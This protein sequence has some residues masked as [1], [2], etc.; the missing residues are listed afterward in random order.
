MRAGLRFKVMV[1]PL[2][3]MS[4]STV[5]LVGVSLW[6]E[7]YLWTKKVEEQS[8]S[9]AMLAK[10][11][12]AAIEKQALTI[13]AIAAE[14]P[15]VEESYTLATSGQ[16]G[17][18]R[19]LL[20]K[21]TDPIHQ[22]VTETLGIKK[23]KIHFHLPPAKSFLRIWEEA[24]KKDGGEDISGFR[25]S[26]VKVNQEKKP[27][28]A[29]EVGRGGFEV[30]GIVP[31]TKPAGEHLGSV[32]TL[33]ELNRVFETAHILDT[34]DMA[35]YMGVKEL[36]IAKDLK[37]KRLP[38]TAG[39]VRIF[40]SNKENTD[41]YVDADLL[42]RCAS[43]DRAA[44]EKDGRLLTA[45]PLRDFSGDLKGVLVF[46]RDAS[47]E[48]AF[49]KTLEWALI[50]GGAFL[51]SAV[52]LFLYLSSSSIITSL[53]SAINRLEES[54]RNVSHSSNEIS[55]SSQTVASGASE[56]AAALEET[57]ASMEETTSMIKATAANS[58]EADNLMQQTATITERAKKSME[59]LIVSMGEISR[60]SEE[61]SKIIKT[62]DEIAFQTNLL[63][64]NAA[65]EAARAGE[66]GSGF[67]VVA[68]EVRNLA[69]RATEA[70]RNTATLIESTLE[71]VKKGAIIAGSSNETFNEVASA[72]RKIGELINDISIA[73]RE[74]ALGV[75]QINKTITEM[76]SVTQDNAASAEESAAASEELKGQAARMEEIVL[77]LQNILE[78]KNT[79]VAKQP[80]VARTTE[81]QAK[82]ATADQ[83]R[84][85]GPKPTARTAAKPQSK[86]RSAEEII[87]LEDDFQDF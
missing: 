13:A 68:D 57:S 2:L 7:N 59:E 52:C 87:P 76:E 20:R 58:A 86:K 8:R 43:A 60:A 71:K 37:E 10:K 48:L 5:F 73:S 34:D 54:S 75:D 17:E 69:M 29:I 45:I 14:L 62:I 6:V 25:P 15:G 4:L 50:G 35:V 18:G 55:V 81:R 3:L 51:L 40:S 64:L 23:F 46:V 78:G 12:L 70:A 16:E 31:V 41:P 33:L 56:Q 66:A 85:P 74:Q 77:A 49:I 61:T 63:A 32:E 11:S 83:A 38:E 21:S 47:V 44:E 27:L 36:D 79:K 24:G 65:V 30:R 42:H 9:Q 1:V 39:F 22:K 53:T 67:A 82:P 19:T 26:V 28:S 80:G 84:L 72:S